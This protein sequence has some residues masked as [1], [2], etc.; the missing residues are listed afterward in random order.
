MRWFKTLEIINQ[1]MFS[2]INYGTPMKQ[3][4]PEK[5]LQPELDY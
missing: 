4:L 5:N 3:L 1:Y 2:L